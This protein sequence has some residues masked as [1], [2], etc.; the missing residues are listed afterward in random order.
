LGLLALGLF[1]SSFLVVP[2]GNDLPVLALSARY[3]ERMLYGAAMATVVFWTCLFADSLTF[4]RV[5]VYRAAEG[6]QLTALLSQ[7]E[8]RR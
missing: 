7:V 5:V 4:C 6:Q 3:H 8:L 2:M 1:D